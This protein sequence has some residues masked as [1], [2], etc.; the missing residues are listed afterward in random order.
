MKK[1]SLAVQIFLFFIFV[2]SILNT[3]ENCI[4]Q[5]TQT[6]GPT[7][8]YFTTS[9]VV[10]SN[11]FVGSQGNGLYLSNNNGAQWR[12]ISNTPFSDYVQA[13]FADGNDLYVG[14]YDGIFKTSDNGSTWIVLNNDT[15]RGDISSIVKC[16]TTLFAG[17]KS[18]VYYSSDNGIHW[19]KT[20]LNKNIIC[21][22]V[23]G[24]TI[25]AGTLDGVFVSTDLGASWNNISQGIDDQYIRSILVQNNK[26]FIGTSSGLHTSTNN[27]ITWT[28]S[29]ILNFTI[30]NILASNNIIFA[31]SYGR[32]IYRS[33]DKGNFWTENDLGLQ[34]KELTF[35]A[36]SGNNLFCGVYTSG[37]YI[38]VNNGSTWVK[39]G[40]G[41][42]AQLV[43]SLCIKGNYL[44]AGTFGQA[45]MYRSDDDGSSWLPE[46][47]GLNLFDTRCIK[48][49]NN[50]LYAG[51][52]GGIYTSTNDGAT[53]T[54]LGLQ[55]Q[56]IS[57]ISYSDGKLLAGGFQ[58]IYIS[59]DNGINWNVSGPMLKG[60][61]VNSLTVIGTL[62]IAG[63][64]FGVF[65]STNG[66][67]NWL[68]TR[69]NSIG[70]NCITASG[71]NFFAGT[72]GHG[73][74]ISSDNGDNWNQT[75]LTDHYI[76][77]IK[78][79]DNKV[80][81]AALEGLYISINNGNSWISKREGMPSNSFTFAMEM[82]ADNI[83]LGTLGY[84]VWK[85]SY[86]QT[87]GIQSNSAVLPDKFN[88]S[89]NYPNPFNPTTKINF[90]LPVSSFVTLKIYNT[91]GKEV[92]KLVNNDLAAGSYTYD[93]DAASLSSGIYFYQ[94]NATGS[95]SFTKTMRMVLVK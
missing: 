65:R 23:S 15:I 92:A 66:G 87:V 94:I 77:D 22:T 75:S 2:G 71:S 37:V 32:G 93:F 21:M 57:S 26:L 31:A 95:Q 3:S 76:L 20:H 7:G 34:S 53:W 44:F 50:K 90:T 74:F 49:I 29:T 27:G 16:G 17:K 56:Y 46:N 61:S 36:A 59:S 52:S 4:A 67:E 43:C 79:R 83:F 13:L 14:S 35:I 6:N 88:L 60:G 81:A 8:G 89:Q 38:S 30:D 55:G 69:L 24:N 18:D 47:Q 5:W 85:R 70:I 1:R 33:T 19:H 12:A 82:N 86:S 63:T 72:Q 91:T 78:S 62:V 11:I 80:F 48:V 41:L 58:Q 54:F 45:G 28:A 10:G 39:T 51:G 42:K 25:Y 9:A 68:S 73:I 84:S 40:N 64:D